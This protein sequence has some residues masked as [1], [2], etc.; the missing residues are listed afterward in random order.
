MS[1]P[2]DLTWV[3]SSSEYII[4][5]DEYNQILSSEDFDIASGWVFSDCNT[6]KIV[7]EQPTGSIYQPV[8][9]HA[10]ATLDDNPCTSSNPDSHP[11]PTIDQI[12]RIYEEMQQSLDRRIMEAFIQNTIPEHSSN[13]VT[14]TGLRQII[15]STHR[16]PSVWIPRQPQTFLPEARQRLEQSGIFTE[17]ISHISAK[18]TGKKVS[19]DDI[20]KLFAEI[21]ALIG[22]SQ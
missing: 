20:D 19:I 10:R 8:T 16:Y 3:S 2:T 6:N 12:D 11:I 5:V 17:P 1:N 4:G 15:A 22:D 9:H 18:S 14:W 21:D 7:W 13:L